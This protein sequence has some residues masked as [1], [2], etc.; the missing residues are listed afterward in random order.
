MSKEG[1]YLNYTIV[2]GWGQ[3]EDELVSFDK[4]LLSAGIEKFNLVPVSSILPYRCEYQSF[5]KLRELQWGTVIHVILA[6]TIVKGAYQ[7][8]AGLCSVK[9]EDSGRVFVVEYAGKVNEKECRRILEKRAKLVAEARDF[10]IS[11]LEFI[12]ESKKGR[13]NLYTCVIVAICLW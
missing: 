10:E 3:S 5:E 11:D 1:F 4:A 2:R 9:E 6:K 7:V 8:S 13:K 12:I